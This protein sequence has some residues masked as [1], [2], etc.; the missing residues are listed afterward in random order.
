[1]GSVANGS[2]KDIHGSGTQAG[3]G[4]NHFLNVD[5]LWCD[6]DHALSGFVM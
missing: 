3:G 1:V 4:V 2:D 5:G 6:L